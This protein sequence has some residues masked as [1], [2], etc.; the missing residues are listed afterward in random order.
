MTWEAC[1]FLCGTVPCAIAAA[2]VLIFAKR[3]RR[4]ALCVC[5]AAWCVFLVW[6]WSFIEPVRVI[7]RPET[8]VCTVTVSRLSGET[9]EIRDAD[10][11]SRL[12]GVYAGKAYTR[13]HDS[14]TAPTLL[15]LEF[16]SAD[17]KTRLELWLTNTGR[18]KFTLGGIAYERRDRSPYIDTYEQIIELAGW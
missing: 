6:Y 3:Y 18:V 15:R 16:R 17:G 10:E 7:D 11:A 8:A 12:L 4:G 9:L 13:C 5:A 14:G 1:I 2:C